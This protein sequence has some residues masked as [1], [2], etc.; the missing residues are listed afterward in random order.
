MKYNMKSIN[1]YWLVLMVTLIAFGCQK[2]YI[3]ITE[4]G[5]E[6]VISANDTLA[7][8]IHNV[9]LKDG[10]IDNFIDKC[11]GF[12]IKF[13]YEV[14]IND[15]V[16]TINS[17][18][19]INKL[20]YDY[21]EYHDD[22]EIIFPITIILHDYTEI[23]LND[24]DE[25]EELREQFDELEDDDIECVDFIFPIEL[26]TYNI[27]FQK[28]ENVV[29][30]NDSELYNLFDDLEDDIIIE[31]LYPIQ[32]LFYNEDTIRVNNNTELKEMISVLSDGCDEDDV[33]EFNE[34]D[35]PFA[36]LLTSNAWI[37]S[38]YSDAS[39]KT[40]AFMGYTF[41]FYP[42]Y[43][44]KAE[45]SQESIPGEWKLYIEELENIIEIEFD[46]DDES[47]DWLNEDWEI[48]EAGSQGVKLIA[49]GDEEDRNKNL[50]F[51]RLE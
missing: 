49:Q 43:T 31:M 22:I 2:E 26:M 21:Y 8:L 34:E 24:E 15:Q 1:L 9:V 13:P 45:H 7:R 32:L 47:L 17:D 16:F 37:V 35:Y 25:L 50:Y 4:P 3:E 28:H 5:E 44:L 33:I 29:V 42:N 12:S 27:T 19:D 40:S 6:E 39:D 20:K 23:I 38:L 41:V 48:I 36:E 14:E 51:S 46:T 11:S 30:K 18:A 10:S